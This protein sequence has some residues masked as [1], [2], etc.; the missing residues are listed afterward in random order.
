MITL[1]TDTDVDVN[2]D[3]AKELGFKL[4]SM[5][6]SI[7]G[8]NIRPYKDFKEFDDKAFY[9]ALRNGV[10]PQ[11]SAVNPEEYKEY[12]EEEFKKGNDIFYIHFAKAMSGTFNNLR[13]AV[14]ELKEEYPDRNV[15]LLDSKGISICTLNMLYDI[16][17]LWKKGA[18]IEDITS[19]TL[20]H[21]KNYP[22][23]FFVTDL[24][25]FKRSGRVSGLAAT[26]G[27]I[28]GIH[29]LLH[30]NEEGKLIPIGKIKGKKKAIQKLLD[31]VD[32]LQVDIYDHKVILTHADEEELCNELREKLIQKYGEKLDIITVPVNPTVGC[33]CGPG[34]VGICF[35]GKNR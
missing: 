33:H 23:Y 18:S 27:N 5:P 17:A 1:F 30:I 6:Y 4:I 31:Y 3:T 12:F 21:S 34:T 15:Y 19:W 20:E 25:F 11:T 24:S 2:L 28:I 8:E 10:M 13:L 9:T 26:I 29:P 32:E 16:S 7:N 14:E 22:T 35:Y